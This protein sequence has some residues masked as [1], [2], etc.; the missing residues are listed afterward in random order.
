M[1]LDGYMSKKLR[2]NLN[3]KAIQEETISEDFCRKFIG[4]KGFNT[5][6]LLDEVGPE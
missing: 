5:K 4:G 6:I 3:K 1:P 2:I